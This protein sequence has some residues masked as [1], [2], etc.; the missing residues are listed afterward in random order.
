MNG[1]EKITDKITAD[2]A[3]ESEALIS[4]AQKEADD[5]V[6]S[7]EKRAETVRRNYAERISARRAELSARSEASAETELRNAALKARSELVDEVFAEAL[8]K[9]RRLPDGQYYELLEKLYL[10]ACKARLAEVTSEFADEDEAGVEKYT[11]AMNSRDAKAFGEHLIS[12]F[13]AIDGKPVVLSEDP[14][15]LDGGFILSWGNVAVNCTLSELVS[16]AKPEL[17][18]DVCRILYPIKDQ[19]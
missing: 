3:A 1:I 8:A 11:L 15:D 17:E 9:L 5:I 12:T 4:Q 6:A 16:S 18:L 2:A 7:A 13:P 14:C 19:Q 10:R